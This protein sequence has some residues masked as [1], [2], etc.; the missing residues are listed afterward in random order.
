V[1]KRQ[2]YRRV[3]EVSHDKK[4]YTLTGTPLQHWLDTKL[5]WTAHAR[6]LAKKA[7]IQIGALTRTTASTCGA[8]FVRGRQIYSSVVRPLLAYGAA[9]WHIPTCGSIRKAKGLAAKLQVIQNKCLRTI[10]GAYKATPIASLETETYIPPI[11]LYLDSRVAAFQKRLQS[12][13]SYELV[14]NVCKV[15]QRRI[16]IRR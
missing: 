5:R 9:T 4:Q 10:A 11:D 16:K 6:K 1:G 13:S 12:S 8:T 14:R 7:A 15:I 2:L 3:S